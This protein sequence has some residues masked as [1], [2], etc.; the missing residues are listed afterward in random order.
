[1][2]IA[3]SEPSTGL[4]SRRGLRRGWRRRVAGRVDEDLGGKRLPAALV[5]HDQRVERTA[6]PHRAADDG[7]QEDVASA[8]GHHLV[9]HVLEVLRV[10]RRDASALEACVPG[11]GPVEAL[12]HLG[13]THRQLP[14][15]AADDAFVV[16]GPSLKVAHESGGGHAAQ[17][18]V[19]LDEQGAGAVARRGDGG[20]DAGRATPGHDD[21]DLSGNGRLRVG[22]VTVLIVSL[23]RCVCATWSRPARLRKRL[24][25][26]SGVAHILRTGGIFI[27]SASTARSCP[28]R[29]ALSLPPSEGGGPMPGTPLSRKVGR[30]TLSREERRSLR[31]PSS[32][33]APGGRSEGRGA[34]SPRAHHRPRQ[35]EARAAKTGDPRALR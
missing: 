14:G 32:P 6:R 22:S 12:V 17:D 21:V 3:C 28:I 20:A 24:D 25:K 11:S 33:P 16:D 30:R 2:V 23:S 26:V 35:G 9:G 13:D 7:V 10:E 31:S 8:L 19:L 1:M 4:P 29:S 5:L 27:Q 18:P 15:K 34:S